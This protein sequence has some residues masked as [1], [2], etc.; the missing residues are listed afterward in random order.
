MTLVDPVI[1]EHA[2]G[3]LTGVL[4]RNALGVLPAPTIILLPGLVGTEKNTDIAHEV[5]K[6]GWNAFVLNYRGTWGCPGRYNLTTHH[7]EA[8][9]LIEY[10]SQLSISRP[11]EITVLGYSLGSRAALLT[12]DS[13]GECRIILL[14]GVAY[15]RKGALTSDFA[16]TISPFLPGATTE[17]VQRQWDVLAESEQPFEL[18][19]K[20]AH[21][22]IVLIHGLSDKSVPSTHSRLLHESAKGSILY[23]IEKADHEYVSHRDQ[24][25]RIVLKELCNIDCRLESTSVS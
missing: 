3:P 11:E 9:Y 19:S 15:L 13:L 2:Q 10:L 16:E 4:Y 20:V 8:L 22:H 1:I 24:L 18:A 7:E 12:A 6:A 5:Q 17:D 21:N 23:L 25:R 14:S